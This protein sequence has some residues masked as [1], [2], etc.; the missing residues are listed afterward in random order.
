MRPGGIESLLAR[1]RRAL[2]PGPGGTIALTL[3][4]AGA[5]ILMV[6]LALGD[7]AAHVGIGATTRTFVLWFTIAWATLGVILTLS[8]RLA[9]H[10][11]EQRR[12]PVP[13]ELPRAVV[14][15]RSSSD[16]P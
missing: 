13:V 5:L 4:G 16:A 8:L 10:R 3:A 15:V 6:S 1:A 9:E 2:V 12:Q 11:A 14:H 7:Q